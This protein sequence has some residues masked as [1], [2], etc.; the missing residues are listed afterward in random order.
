MPN[1]QMPTNAPSSGP[2]HGGVANASA[3]PTLPPQRILFA[4]TQIPLHLL[5]NRPAIF[6]IYALP[7]QTD[8]SPTP[9]PSPSGKPG[10]AGSTKVSGS[11][12]PGGN[13]TPAAATVETSSA[14]Q[15]APT[16]AGAPA[17]AGTPQPAKSP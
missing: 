17:A 11:P 8:A 2:G 14:P 1:G 13:A 9:L 12:A 5:A 10:A 3:A 4:S 7:Q 15:A 6:A 16:T